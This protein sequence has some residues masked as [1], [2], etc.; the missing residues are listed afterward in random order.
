MDPDLDL[1]A[2]GDAIARNM[3]FKQL[4]LS[5]FDHEIALIVFRLVFGAFAQSKP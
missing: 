5:G 1:R 2:L 3:H 4:L